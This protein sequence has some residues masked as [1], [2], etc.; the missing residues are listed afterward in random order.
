VMTGISET[1]PIDGVA[2]FVLEGRMTD[3]ALVR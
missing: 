2:S 1:D 3:P